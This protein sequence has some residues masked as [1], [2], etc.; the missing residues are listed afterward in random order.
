MDKDEKSEIIKMLVD[1][2]EKHEKFSGEFERSLEKIL[3]EIEK[4]KE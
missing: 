3:I 2:L 1:L 4:L